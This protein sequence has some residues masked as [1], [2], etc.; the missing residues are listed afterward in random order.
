MKN[1][2]VFALKEGFSS[3]YERKKRLGQYFSGE[4][5]GRL[6][7]NLAGV[8]SDNTVLDTMAGSGDLLSSCHE[9]GVAQNALSGIEVDPIAYKECNRRLNESNCVLGSAFE[10]SS[11]SNFKNREW[12]VVITNPPYVRY[13]RMSSRA[14]S[15]NLLSNATEIRSQLLKVL[16]SLSHLDARDKEI[17]SNLIKN[18][19]GLSDLAVPSW[20]LNSLLVKEG[21]TFALV[22]PESWLSRDYALIVKYIL[23]RWFRI[24]YIVEDANACWFSEAQVKTTL[25]IARRIPRKESAFDFCEHD[26]FLKV[27]IFDKAKSNSSLVGNLYP[28]NDK[29]ERLFSGDMRECLLSKYSIHSEMLEVESVPLS[30]MILGVEKYIKNK[31]WF[32]K[33]ESNRN[34]NSSPLISFPYEMLSWS[35]GIKGNVKFVDLISLGVRFGQGLRTGANSFF[36][37][38]L[39]SCDIDYFKV[40]TS[41]LTGFSEIKVSHEHVMKVI[42]RQSELPIGYTVSDD[43]LLGCVLTIEGYALSEDILESNGLARE[44]YTA[45]D[46]DLSDYIR[47]AELINFGSDSNPKKVVELSAVSTNVRTEKKG[48]AERYW[49]MLPS[50]ARR[51]KPDMFLARVN[52]SSPKVFLNQDSKAIIDANF[53]TVWLEGESKLDVYSLLAIMNSTL[54]SV[55]LECSAS[56]MGGGALK[57]E[58]THLKRLSIPDF[59]AIVLTNLSSLGFD[60][61]VSVSDDQSKEIVRK[62]DEEIISFIFEEDNVELALIDLEELK[63]KALV[64]RSK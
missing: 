54:F 64:K 4:K 27:S 59:T 36:Y 47:R 40:R 63:N 1:I 32:G 3:S 12:D 7:A 43:D 18:Y 13:Q 21:G 56:V 60:L 39:I 55:F 34:I 48:S 57:V 53:S 52:N 41:K 37:L 9:L 33:V 11:Y 14:G 5:L 42:R 15:D 58:A 45:L 49:Y 19:S 8:E 61:S 20:I 46:S 25:L 16:E 10:E 50:I 51:H 22:L 62:I 6:L 26:N 17:F 2:E 38:D 23:F 35:N 44:E 31:K 29:P 28:S 24:E 30:N